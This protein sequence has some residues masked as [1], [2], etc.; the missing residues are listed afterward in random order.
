MNSPTSGLRLLM[1]AGL[2]GSTRPGLDDSWGPPASR[3]DK[4]GRRR[5]TARAVDERHAAVGAEEE[6]LANV[7]ARLAAVLVVDGIDQAPL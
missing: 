4:S 2:V 3:D 5:G 7:S 6:R 1:N